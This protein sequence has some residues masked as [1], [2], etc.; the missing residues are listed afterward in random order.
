MRC[1]GCPQTRAGCLSTLL[2]SPG[3]SPLLALQDTLFGLPASHSF[4]VDPAVSP[5]PTALLSRFTVLPVA[6]LFS[7]LSLPIDLS[8]FHFTLYN[9]SLSYS[10]QNQDLPTLGFPPG[11]AVWGAG[12]LYDILPVSASLTLDPVTFNTTFTV[13]ASATALTVGGGRRGGMPAL[14]GGWAGG[15]VGGCVSSLAVATGW[16]SYYWGGGVVARADE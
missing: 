7:S 13:E 11:V 12:F 15:C 1:F 16:M 6:T 10:D 14:V 2:S 3:P 9:A 4:L 8:P 5:S